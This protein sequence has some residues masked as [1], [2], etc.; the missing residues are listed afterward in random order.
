LS[1]RDELA[2][3]VG[4]CVDLRPWLNKQTKKIA[5]HL[6]H[7]ETGEP[8][9]VCCEFYMRSLGIHE[10]KLKGVRA[11]VRAGHTNFVHLNKHK[12]YET[13]VLH[14]AFLFNCFH[15]QA[16]KAART[17]AFWRDYFHRICQVVSNE[18]IVLPNG[19]VLHLIY[20]NVFLDWWRRSEYAHP[21]TGELIE[22]PSLATFHNQ[23]RHHELGHVNRKPKHTHL[24]CATC[25][26]MRAEAQAGFANDE[27]T[28]V[29]ER[30]Y[31]EHQRVVKL[32]HSVE[33]YTRSLGAHQPSQYMVVLGDDTSAFAIP[34]FTSRDIKGVAT[35]PRLKF[36][37][38]LFENVSTGE[39][40][41]CYHLAKT[42]IKGGN[43]WCTMMHSICKAV[44]ERRAS[45]AATAKHFTFIG[46]DAFRLWFHLF[47]FHRRQLCREQEQHRHRVGCDGGSQGL[48]R[49]RGVFVW[50]RWAYT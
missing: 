31:A 10:T 7:A 11:A 20:T 28:E 49:N 44:K 38:F 34:H 23:S 3:R 19:T 27:D 32:W 5:Y 22:P 40:T 48:V 50:S 41:Y 15:I 14:A 45:P 2:A 13:K 4:L 1:F 8:V 16:L 12:A 43:R 21:T 36:V 24:R 17:R 18:E 46:S 30:A 29:F 37:P 25:A 39:A 9:Q 33:E 35:S 26:T 6:A 42:F 47:L